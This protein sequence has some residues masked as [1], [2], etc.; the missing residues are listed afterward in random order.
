MQNNNNQNN[1]Q[2]P[3][4]DQPTYAGQ[5]QYIPPQVPFQNNIP[6]PPPLNAGQFQ[7]Q[8]VPAPP[9]KRGVFQWYKRQRKGAKIGIGCS[10]L[11]LALC[12]CIC[13]AAA[14]A[15]PAPQ[16]NVTQAPTSTTA[17]QSTHVAFVA[18]SQPTHQTTKST[19][20]PTL[21]PTDTPVPTQVPTAVPTQAPTPIPT[22][23][24]APTPVPT[25]P[26]AQTGLNGN[27]W[28]YDLNTGNLIYSP[29]ADFCNYFSC[30]GTFWTKTNGYVDECSDGTYSHSGGVRGTCSRHGGEA[31]PLY[32]H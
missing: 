3:F 7:Y 20:I 16:N 10:T 21:K 13:S 29:P 19:P 8:P 2:V 9:Q 15:P 26:P 27:P 11:F 4:N 6:P 23:A 18:T 25:Q 24:P 5:Y 1:N 28:G 30:V 12:L 31:Q 17:D 22:K 32:S 14:I